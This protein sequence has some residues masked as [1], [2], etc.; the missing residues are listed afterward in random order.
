MLYLEDASGN[1]IDAAGPVV[2]NYFLKF[3]KKY[4]YLRKTGLV[5][6]VLRAFEWTGDNSEENSL[7]AVP[8][9][10]DIADAM[11]DR[12]RSTWQSLDHCQRTTVSY[13]KT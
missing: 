7:E 5:K 4:K 9:V 8:D 13:Q 6:S 2:A 11:T 10:F 3:Y 1:F 12:F